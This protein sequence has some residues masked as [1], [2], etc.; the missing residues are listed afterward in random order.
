MGATEEARKQFE[1]SIYVDHESAEPQLALAVTLFASGETEQALSIAE[2][3]LNL[4]KRFA[5][6][7][8]LKEN[9]WGDKIISDAEKLLSHPQLQAFLAGR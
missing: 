2:A 3:A 7:E 6:P 4:D 5:D 8:Y 1:Q 9:L